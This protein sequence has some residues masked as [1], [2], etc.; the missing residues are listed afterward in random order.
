AYGPHNGAPRPCG[1]G[2]GGDDDRDSH[3]YV[4][5]LSGAQVP[6]NLHGLDYDRRFDEDADGVSRTP[7]GESSTMNG[8]ARLPLTRRGQA[9]ITVALTAIILLGFAGMA[10][11]VGMMMLTR[12]ELQNAADAAALACA[13][14]L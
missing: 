11:D 5:V 4:P 6:G 1:S 7:P 12:N 14:A 13:D 3:L 10:I 9:L 8:T 2:V